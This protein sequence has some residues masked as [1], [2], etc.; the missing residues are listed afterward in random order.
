MKWTEKKIQINRI[1]KST[2]IRYKGKT[3]ELVELYT[4]NGKNIGG[5]ALIGDKIKRMYSPQ[6]REK[7]IQDCKN[8]IDKKKPKPLPIY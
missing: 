1:R 5:K 3:I 6:L 2:K 8:I 4:E 7:V